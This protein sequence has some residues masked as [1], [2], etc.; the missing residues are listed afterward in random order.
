MLDGRCISQH[1]LAFMGIHDVRSGCDLRD[2]QVSDTR[3]QERQ[4]GTRA[5][6][7]VRRYSQGQGRHPGTGETPRNKGESWGQE[8]RPGT[9]EIPRGKRDIQGQDRHLWTMETAIDKTDNQLPG[10]RETARDKGDTLGKSL[11]RST[12]A[13]TQ[14][15]VLILHGQSA[16]G[17]PGTRP[18]EARTHLPHNH[19]P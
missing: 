10:T 11:P 5:T 15:A 8:R 13:H 2:I 3:G 14:S 4:P 17:R 12:W 6:A 16:A 7:R 1:I 18:N 19:V 9:R